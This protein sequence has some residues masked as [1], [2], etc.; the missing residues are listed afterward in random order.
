MADLYRTL[1]IRRDASE[2]EIRDAY[3]RLARQYH[4][5][6]NPGDGE[7]E[8][9]FKEINAAHQVLS[10]PE[11]RAKYDRHGDQW[12][13][14]DQIEEMRRQQRAAGGAGFSF[15]VDDLFAGRGGAEVD[16]GEIL[17]GGESGGGGL[18][19]RMFQRGGGRGRRRRRGRD[20]EHPVRISLE[21][22][23]G[24][25]TRRVEVSDESGRCAVCGGTGQVASATCHACRGAGT[26]RTTRQ[27]EVR[28]PPGIADGGRV[29]LAG[30]GGPGAAGG[31]PGDLYLRVSIA[32]HPT[33]ARRGD[34]LE[35]DIDVPVWDAALGGEARVPT[36]KGKTLALSIPAGTEGG[37]VFRLAG[38]GMPRADG[39][40]GDLRARVRLTLPAPLSERQ[41]EL[42]AQ[43]RD[44][45]QPAGETQAREAG[46]A[47]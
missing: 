20:I 45:Q 33:F 39:G 1:G 28:I 36:L 35:T 38:Q 31:T 23:Y 2:K 9:R 47:P 18:F 5:D 13:H 14:A 42:L 30:K 10:D 41:R 21:E 32:A 11:S 37:R 34:D 25:A 27:L 12:Q 44:D 16:L 29:R 15:T 7:A 3:R 17:R 43:L 24:G 22:A 19:G 46:A 4:P 6:V 8:E 40:Y 26:A